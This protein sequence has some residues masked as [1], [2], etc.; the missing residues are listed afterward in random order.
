M[1]LGLQFTQRRNDPT[2]NPF[3]FAFGYAG[4]GSRNFQ[5]SPTAPPPREPDSRHDEVLC[6]KLKRS[7]IAELAS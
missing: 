2:G 6:A 3:R 4:R 5:S 1:S 7:K